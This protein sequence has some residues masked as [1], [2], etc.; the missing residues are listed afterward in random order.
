MRREMLLGAEKGRAEESKYFKP[1]IPTVPSFTK[2]DNSFTII[3]DLATSVLF[4][5]TRCHCYLIEVVTV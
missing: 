2:D 5:S 4:V 3:T 1:D